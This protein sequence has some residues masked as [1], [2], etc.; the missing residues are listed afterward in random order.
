MVPIAKQI[1]IRIVRLCKGCHKARIM[2]FYNSGRL[3]VGRHD[4]LA[5]ADFSLRQESRGRPDFANLPGLSAL[6]K[7]LASSRCRLR[8]KRISRNRT[9]PARTGLE[10]AGGLRMPTFRFFVAN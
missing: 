5:L 9:D 10:I 8:P 2:A 4:L 7:H 3:V 1:R 6:K